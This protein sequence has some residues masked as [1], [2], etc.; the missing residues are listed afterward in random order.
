MKNLQFLSSVD[1]VDYCAHVVQKYEVLP[2]FQD[3]V[4]SLMS[5]AMC[6]AYEKYPERDI[7]KTTISMLENFKDEYGDQQ[8]IKA[9]GV[10]AN[11]LLLEADIAIDLLTL[12]E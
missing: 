9:P 3:D 4:M 5:D 7:V 12:D 2:M 11:V 8:K 6:A 1:I 10:D